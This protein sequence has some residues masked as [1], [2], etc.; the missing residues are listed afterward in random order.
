MESRTAIYPP[1]AKAAGI[2]GTVELEA[3][4]SKDGSVKDLSIVSGPV[5]LRQAAVESV[6]TWRYRPFM[7]NN[8]ATEVQTTVNVVFSPNE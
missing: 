6:R 3:T 7:L 8:E 2:S 5:Q 4:I 1:T